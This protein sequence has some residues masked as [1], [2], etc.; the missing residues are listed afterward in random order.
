MSKVDVIATELN[1]NSKSLTKKVKLHIFDFI[2]VGLVMSIALLNLGA[3]E[4]RNVG[5]ELIAILLEAIPFYFGSVALALNF[6]KKGVYAAKQTPTF[7]ETIK[8]YTKK[9]ETLT[10][11]HIDKLNE[12]CVMYNAKALRLK[13]EAILRDI[14]ISFERFN[15]YTKD[16]DGNVLAPLKIVS[17]DV[18]KQTYGDA[19]ATKIIAAKNVTIKGISPNNILGNFNTDDITD[20]GKNETE[21]L[22]ERSSQ[23]AIVYAASIVVLSLMGVKDILQWGW[24]GAF[25]ILFKL[26]YILCRSYMKYFEGY[27]DISIALVNYISRKHDVLKEFDYWFDNDGKK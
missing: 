8:R 16:P 26:S 7:I 18:L 9:V 4:M 25:L 21:M 19:V 27:D 1:E 13:Q 22:K 3:I 23:Y 15:D 12:F 2:A 17:E 20:L 6:Y 10:G 11:K 5:E 24:M 14:A